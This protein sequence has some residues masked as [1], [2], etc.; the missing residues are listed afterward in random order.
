MKRMFWWSLFGMSGT[1]LAALWLGQSVFG[2]PQYI[3]VAPAAPTP[4][5]L[6]QAGPGAPKDGVVRAGVEFP[7][8]L[9]SAGGPVPDGLPSPIPTFVPPSSTPIVPVAAQPAPVPTRSEPPPLASFA[10][11]DKQVPAAPLDVPPGR[12]SPALSIEWAG[13]TTIRVH[14]PMSCQILVRN[15]SNVTLHNVVVRHRLGE[16]VVCNASEPQVS[17]EGGD[18]LW[19]LGTL[20]PEQSRRI[21]LVLVVPARGVVNCHAT[22]TFTVVAGHQVQVREPQLTIKMR[23]A[24]NV[25]AGDTIN[26][27]CDLTNPGDG[28]AEAIKLKAYLPEGLEHPGGHKVIEFDV[29]NLSPKETRTVRLPC[30]A[31]GNGVQ[32]CKIVVVGEGNLTAQDTAQFEI[33][34]PKLDVA[35]SGPKLRYLDR[36]AVYV[37]KVTNP[38]SAPATGIE[39]HELIPAGFRFHQANSGGQFQETTRLVS[40]NVGD[41][42]PGQ[43]K[44]VAVDLIPI[45]VGE[46]RLI[47]H[48]KTAR[49]L[50]SEGQTL[51]MVEGLPSL[52]IEVA[53]AD[54]PI[55]VGAETAFEIRIANTGTKTETNIEVV[56]VLPE[57]L[58]FKG[59]ECKAA[60]KYRLENREL[61]FE[62]LPKLVQKADVIYRVK[63]RGIA[64][65]DI[66]FRTRIR[67]DGVR[68]PLLREES[69]RVYSDDAPP[70]Q[71][72]TSSP[73]PVPS[74]LPGSAPAAMPNIPQ[75]SSIPTVP[76]PTEGRAPVAPS[77]PSPTPSSIPG[78]TPGP[79][80]LAPP[81]LP[82]LP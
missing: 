23:P 69:M 46:Q 76:L 80:P 29:G 24:E 5:T 37:L 4:I 13:P 77:L 47:A 35:V 17:K 62:P 34:T 1:A 57:Q 68:D 81:N 39:V 51:T 78:P 56:C 3:P 30:V 26:F 65:G 31:K 79:A 63:V 52:F 6:P 66:R 67:A 58:E 48:A 11:P 75:P 25:I 19:T 43:S 49:G 61:I 44:D 54:D 73:A 59:A 55:E 74:S 14:Q 71:T 21:D 20:P 27:L 28:I 15:T 2:Q 60:L 50:K 40:W 8:A 36:H 82:P 9:E 7:R 53:H 33:L 70:R 42:Q 18:L 22:A 45:G 10:K 41:L 64:P 16:G 72:P 12:Q 38:G 32:Q